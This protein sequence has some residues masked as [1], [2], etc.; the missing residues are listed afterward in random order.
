MPDSP[1]THLR[2][3]TT[4]IEDSLLYVGGI[5]VADLLA[6]YGSPLYVLDELT[7]RTSMQAY[8]KAFKTYE[9]GVTP[10]Y[11]AK[12]NLCK[13]I[14]SIAQEEGLGIDVVSGGELYT[15]IEAGFPMSK[16]LFNGNN[17]G[18]EELRLALTHDVGMISVDNRHELSL[19]QALCQELGRKAN[20]LLRITPGIECHTHDYIKTG[21]IDSKFGFPLSQLDEV[22]RLILTDYADTINLCGLHA[23]IGSQIFETQPYYDLVTVMFGLMQNIRA[24]HG[25]TMTH[26]NLGGGLGI[27]YQDSDDPPN[28]ADYAAV[29]VEQVL[30]EAKRHEYPLP[31]LFVEPG[32]SIVATAGMTLYTVGSIKQ[33]AEIQKTYVSVDGGMGDNIRPALYGAT[34]SAVVANKASEPHDTVV[35]VA[36]KYCESGDVILPQFKAP[37]SI[38]AGDILAVFATGAYNYSMASQYNRVPRPAVVLVGEARSRVLVRRETWVDLVAMDI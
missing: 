17:K 27:R 25:L 4:T 19:L 9:L 10:M 28:V 21:H 31:E 5:S 7:L 6:R 38:A 20:I 37:V 11:A 3:L 22:V 15:A 36:G 29:V 34:Y 26:L 2:P 12:A 1:N 24:K 18:V 13:G 33:I 8:V 16:I 32:R 23:H 14:C 30:T 35:T